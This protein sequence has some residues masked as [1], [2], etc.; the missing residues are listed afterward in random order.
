[1]AAFLSTNPP[2]R[3]LDKDPKTGYWHEC[4]EERIREKVSQKL[5]QGV[6]AS[7][8]AREASIALTL[9]RGGRVEQNSKSATVANIKCEGKKLFPMPSSLKMQGI[10]PKDFADLN[11]AFI[12]HFVEDPNLR[13]LV[14][15]SDP[16]MIS[17]VLG[18]KE[19]CETMT[20]NMSR[21]GVL[22][23]NHSKRV[24]QKLPVKRTAPTCKHAATPINPSARLTLSVG[25]LLKSEVTG[26]K[27]CANMI[28]Q[29]VSRNDI[30]TKKHR[31]SSE[32]SA[33]AS[34]PSK[35]MDA[36]TSIK[37]SAQLSPSTTSMSSDS[38]KNSMVPGGKASADI[39]QYLSRDD[40][41][42]RFHLKRDMRRLP[43]KRALPPPKPAVTPV[44]PS[45]RLSSPTANTE[46]TELPKI[47]GYQKNCLVKRLKKTDVVCEEGQKP[48][49]H[50]KYRVSYVTDC[51]YNHSS[52]TLFVTCC[53]WK[54]SI[55]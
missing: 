12:M 2:Y 54:H 53:S 14:L 40:V 10:D 20:Q 48:E 30:L 46:T 45:A 43:V 9:L 11:A 37:P 52:L 42:A 15:K 38:R 29:D 6:A 39:T 18:E 16:R 35:F 28:S 36:V 41:R 17:K 24:T 50:R 5:R 3:F 7:R 33:P 21:G 1:M 55:S 47:L 13:A 31:V 22:T 44:K 32:L 26:E 23:K 4:D 27:K 49:D 19:C 34:P 25:L 51:S 8:R